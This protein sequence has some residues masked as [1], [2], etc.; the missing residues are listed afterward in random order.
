MNIQDAA[1]LLEQDKKA[2][3]EA[4]TQEMNALLQ[5]YKVVLVT[6]QE[7]VNGHLQPIQIMLVAQ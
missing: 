6:R 5:K 1:T 4:A 7:I 2:R 3:V